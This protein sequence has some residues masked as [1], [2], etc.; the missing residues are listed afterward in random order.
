MRYLMKLSMPVEPFNSYVKDGSIG[1]RMGK[2]M[3]V[4][5]PEAAYFTAEGG[6]RGGTLVVNID[7]ANQLPFLA[8]PW[9]IMFSAKVEF[10]PAMTPEDMGN[11]GLESLG[12]QWS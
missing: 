3:E 2:I 8:E 5:R 12:K 11:S 6:T 1:A 7:Q 4:T 10:F 9:F